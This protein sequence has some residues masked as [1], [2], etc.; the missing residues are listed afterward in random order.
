VVTTGRRIEGRACMSVRPEYLLQM[1]YAA[2]I[3]CVSEMAGATRWDAGLPALHS[4]GLRV[5]MATPHGDHYRTDGWE[6]ICGNTVA[7]VAR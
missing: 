2:Y 4:W 5:I 6:L 1:G 7:D 3:E